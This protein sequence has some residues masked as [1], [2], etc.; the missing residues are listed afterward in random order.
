MDKLKLSAL[1][2]ASASGDEEAVRALLSE[3]VPT[4]VKDSVSHATAESRKSLRRI[5]AI[6]VFAACAYGLR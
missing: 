5:A 1:L 4:N 2:T 3:D 6:P